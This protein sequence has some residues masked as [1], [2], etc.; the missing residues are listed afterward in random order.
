M[1]EKLKIEQLESMPQTVEEAVGVCTGTGGEY[2]DEKAIAFLRTHRAEAVEFCMQT[3][4]AYGKGDNTG[5]IKI[6]QIME[7]LL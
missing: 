1:V 2:N 7:K 4:E 6:G 3:F 5:I